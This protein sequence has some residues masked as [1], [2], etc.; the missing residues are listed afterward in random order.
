MNHE[1]FGVLALRD[2]EEARH[3]LEWWSARCL[4]QCRVDIARHLF[5]DQRWM[6]LAPSF[7]SRCHILRHPG[8]NVAYWNL[9]HRRVQ[10][11]AEGL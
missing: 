4:T 7:V 3:L 9:A 5:T 10:R 6:D 1:I 8:Y 11:D 2:D